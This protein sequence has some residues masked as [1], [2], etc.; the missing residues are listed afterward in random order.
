MESS[1]YFLRSGEWSHIRTSLEDSSLWCSEEGRKRQPAVMGAQQ[2]QMQAHLGDAVASFG[3][4][5]VVAHV[6]LSDVSV[7]GHRL[8]RRRE[9]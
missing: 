6:D 5:I 3:H 4:D 1:G 8:E 9:V 7:H 2:W